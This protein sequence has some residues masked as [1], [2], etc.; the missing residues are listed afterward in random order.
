[1]ENNITFWKLIKENII[2]IPIIQRY[3]AQ[4]RIE[5]KER[6]DKF[7]E[8]LYNHLNDPSQPP[9]NLD[10]VYGRNDKRENITVFFPI[11][12]QQ[13]LTTLFLLH[14]YIAKKEGVEASIL[15]ELDK[16]EYD[17]RICT[18]EFCKALI[19]E[20]IQIPNAITDNVLSNAICN[21]FWFRD[22]WNSDPTIQAMLVML[23]AIHDKFHETNGLWEKLTV[24]NLISFQ[25]LDLGKKGFELT[26]ELY[27]KMNA[28]GKQLTDF[29]N[30]K[31]SFIKTLF[32]YYPEEKYT[33]T[34][35][36]NNKPMSYCDYFSYRIEKEWCD[37]FWLYRNKIDYSIDTSFMNFFTFIAQMCYFKDNLDK[38][39]D[40]FKND[41]DIFKKEENLLF[42]FNI[43]D[44]LCKISCEN[45]QV[46]REKIDNFF[47]D[48]F[49]AGKINDTFNEQ[50]RLFEDE[51]KGVNLFE[52]CLSEGKNF[53]NRNRIILFCVFKYVLTYNLNSSTT[54]LKWF[55]RV[56]RNLL[57]ARRQRQETV[58][59]T[60]VRIN[61]F[62]KYWKLFM[63]L[64]EHENVYKCLL[65]DIGIK[66]TEIKNE[67]LNNEK[68]KAEIIEWNDK[69]I[70]IAL[71]KLE[72]FKHFGGLIHQLRPKENTK[73]LK[74]Y[75]QAV[76]EIWNEDN[77]CY[78]I[79]AAM[80]ASDFEGFY[81]KDCA[82]GEMGMWFFG[83][84][85]K[86]N[87]LLSA[88]SNDDKEGKISKSILQLLDNYL[89][90]NLTTS[91]K[92]KLTNIIDNYL[93]K[94][95]ERNWKYYFLKYRANILSTTHNYFAM[96][97]DFEI[98]ILGS[99]SLRPLMAYHINPYVLEVSKS[100]NDTICETN[101]CYSQYF[102]NPSGLVFK[103]RVILYCE[104]EGWRIVLPE[105]YLLEESTKQYFQIGDELLLKEMNGKDR[106]EIAKEFGNK[107][108]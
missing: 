17:T 104:Q 20:N 82:Y 92:E 12:G 15:N 64:M 27:I 103:N 13:R 35:P 36:V 26:D 46:C 99:D 23:Q 98:R 38:N 9:L 58:Y 102:T 76:N 50:V 95:T 69:E 22:A 62:G 85:D 33:L 106:I 54:E 94:L 44:W 90:D 11:D 32:D 61:F 37:L 79:T 28:R 25:I 88:A 83:T 42:L 107:F 70:N 108:N 105:G 7:L 53:D 29:E 77:E 2:N 47:S 87:T 10:F 48:V 100:L 59:Y 56:I 30:F 89:S 4:G 14:W 91:P 65:G 18:R 81:T 72:E 43:L 16:F 57:Q 45:N 97:N 101:N 41:F 73:K 6:R 93:N 60:D 8:V 66:D 24:N 21:K 75:L 55:I 84:H 31:A 39:V 52:K 67:S 80:I 68:Q 63:Q 86:W 96:K 19:K 49:H 1:M 78:L 5:E 51:S 34:H 40:D 3:Y 71:F 74:Q